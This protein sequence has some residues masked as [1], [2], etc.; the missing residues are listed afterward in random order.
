ML[1]IGLWVTFDRA[2]RGGGPL[3]HLTGKGQ[4]HNLATNTPLSSGGYCYENCI[5]HP[6]Y[7]F[8]HYLYM[9]AAKVMAVLC[10]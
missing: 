1:S 7:A 9:F 8:N 4:D 6:D 3:R 5:I 10:A 2:I